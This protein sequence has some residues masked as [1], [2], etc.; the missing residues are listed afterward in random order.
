MN[1][2]R[3]LGL[4]VPCAALLAFGSLSFVQAGD[5]DRGEQSD[6]PIKLAPGARLQRLSGGEA[7]KGLNAA[8]T[9]G[10][11][12]KTTGGSAT[13]SLPVWTD[14]VKSTRDGKTYALQIVG[15]S[16]AKGGPTSIATYL[17]PVKLVFSYSSTTS[18]VFDPTA[19]DPGCLATATTG[20]ANNT[21]VSLTE[22]SPVF[23]PYALTTGAD[24]DITQYSDHF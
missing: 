8:R 13:F 17:I 19:T 5:D 1:C 15:Q 10:G 22:A 11:S 20:S 3:G 23:T 12:A 6:Q 9:S 21:A 16:P 4:A 14:T 18:F 24:S 7:A 2:C